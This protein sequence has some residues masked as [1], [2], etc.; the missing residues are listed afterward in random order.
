MRLIQDILALVLAQLAVFA[1]RG[2]AR[3]QEREHCREA[4][5]LI[6][7]VFGE[8]TLRRLSVLD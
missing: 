8:R 1:A 3:E 7:V 2:A 4:L 6:T 5:E